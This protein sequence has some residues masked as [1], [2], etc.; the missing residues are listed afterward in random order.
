MKILWI[1]PFLPYDNVGH[2]G[3]KLLN[4]YINSLVDND[5]FDVR[6][7]GFSKPSEYE[8]FTL[9]KKIDCYISIYHDHGIKKVL[10]NCY[11]LYSLKCPFDKNGNITTSYL[12]R[13][14]LKRL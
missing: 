12:K 13:C 11:D 2:A 14:I 4:Y 10:R 6:Y 1:A 3:G 8:H 9:D 7:I 5:N